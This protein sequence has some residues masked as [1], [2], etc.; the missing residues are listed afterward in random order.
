MFDSDNNLATVLSTECRFSPV[1]GPCLDEPCLNG[2]ECRVSSDGDSFDCD[3]PEGFEAPLC[4]PTTTTTSTVSTTT[5]TGTPSPTCRQYLSDCVGDTDCLGCI[6]DPARHDS[7]LNDLN[8]SI[9]G[10]TC[11]LLC[12]ALV[13]LIRADH[14]STGTSCFALVSLQ[15]LSVW[16]NY[17]AWA[18]Q[19]RPMNNALVSA[20]I[21]SCSHL[22]TWAFPIPLPVDFGMIITQSPTS[23]TP[24]P[25]IT[26][27][28]SRSEA[29]L[30]DDENI[31]YWIAGAVT[32]LVLIGVIIVLTLRGRRK[33]KE[34]DLDLHPR[35]SII[36]SKINEIENKQFELE[37][38][39]TVDRTA[40]L[41]ILPTSTIAG[42]PHSYP[43]EYL[44][45]TGSTSV[46]QG[47]G[48]VANPV[49]NADHSSA[50]DHDTVQTWL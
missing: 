33:R 50:H 49:L 16:D 1:Y 38:H 22:S 28:E 48:V 35:P 19:C 14:E 12:Q 45:W 15:N 40:V 6:E 9:M 43:L 46:M 41:D 44:T 2:G 26:L 7:C 24:S 39:D 37:S 34:A 10:A 21:D 3:C 42:K 32:L 13:P 29:S 27:E 47:N 20:A 25:P 36:T 18:F 8:Y 31:L 30:F 23:R 11:G 17:D 4:E 5:T